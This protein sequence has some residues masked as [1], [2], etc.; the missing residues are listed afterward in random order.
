MRF[1]IF[2]AIL[3]ATTQ[4]RTIFEAV[5]PG[6]CPARP[7]AKVNFDMEKFSGLWYTIK[8]V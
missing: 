5:K 1:T 2:T 8:G 6:A 3:A 4:G 7:M